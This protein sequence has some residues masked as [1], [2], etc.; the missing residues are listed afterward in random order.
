VSFQ[1][2]GHALKAATLLPFGSAFP[3][4]PE[5][6]EQPESRDSIAIS[7]LGQ[8]TADPAVLSLR[9][10][11][12]GISGSEKRVRNSERLIRAA[13]YESLGIAKKK[14]SLGRKSKPRGSLRS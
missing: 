13:P 4:H 8:G 3:E 2:L 10:S 9:S 12:S 6:P 14:E 5:H 7:R 11:L 1:V